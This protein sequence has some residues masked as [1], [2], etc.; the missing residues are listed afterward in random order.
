ML[1]RGYIW[2]FRRWIYR[3]LARLGL[4]T[5]WSNPDRYVRKPH[6][7][8]FR[9]GDEAGLIA[10]PDGSDWDKEGYR[11]DGWYIWPFC[12]EPGCCRPNGP[13]PTKQAARKWS[14]EN[15]AQRAEP[16]G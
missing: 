4:V 6:V 12:G 11:L 9:K 5:D 13:F 10:L 15:G 3:K 16:R 8:Y 2:D 14:R 7:V 1:W